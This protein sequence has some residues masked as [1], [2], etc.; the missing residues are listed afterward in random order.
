[1]RLIRISV[2]ITGL[3]SSVTGNTV[4]QLYIAGKTDETGLKFITQNISTKLIYGVPGFDN[5]RQKRFS[6]GL[7]I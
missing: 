1:M 5:R 3:L 2:S 4:K 7:E 6:F